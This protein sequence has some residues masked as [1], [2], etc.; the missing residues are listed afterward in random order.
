MSPLSYPIL[1]LVSD[2]HQV[3]DISQAGD[4]LV[5]GGD[6]SSGPR[7]EYLEKTAILLSLCKLRHDHLPL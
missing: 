7:S 2:T 6:D 1:Q 5:N 3:S 4:A